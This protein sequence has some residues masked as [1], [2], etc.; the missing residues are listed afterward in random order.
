MRASGFAVVAEQSSFVTD[1]L[2]LM[3]PL[4]EVRERRMFGGN[5]RVL[6]GG[7]FALVSR[8]GGLCL[9]A[10]DVNRGDFQEQGCKTHGKMP[11]YSVP[12]GALDSWR[13]LEPWAMGTVAASGRAKSLKKRKG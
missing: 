9:K 5:G 3:V 10:V 2:S 12:P 6:D 7:M 4:G 1:V 8:D 11:Y 13:D